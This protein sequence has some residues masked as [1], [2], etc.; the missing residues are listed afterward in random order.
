MAFRRSDV[1]TTG[2]PVAVVAESYAVVPPG[3][4][5]A[6]DSRRAGAGA[7][8]QRRQAALGPDTAPARQPGGLRPGG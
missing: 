3:R 8:A 7:A 2:E 5:V 1:I 4:S 6:G